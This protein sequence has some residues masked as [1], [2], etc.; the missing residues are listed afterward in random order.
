[1]HHPV[2]AIDTLIDAWPV[3]TQ[4][5]PGA[6]CLV[7]GDGPLRSALEGRARRRN[8]AASVCFLGRQPQA[9]L[10]QLLA[11]ADAYVSTSLSDSTSLSLLEAMSAGAYPVV[12]AIDG[13]REWVTPE[14]GSL[15]PPKD[16]GALARALTRALI[17]PTRFDEARAHNRALIESRGDWNRAM[18]RVAERTTA[19]ALA[20]RARA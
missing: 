18:D 20:G 6:R 8:V 1:M 9:S 16:V 13:N 12:S 11:G 19:L 3:V 7:A 15:F 17:D 4:A 2:Y 5:I 10:A 14:S